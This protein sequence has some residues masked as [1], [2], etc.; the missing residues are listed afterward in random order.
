MRGGG[1]N[2][3][4]PSAPGAASVT[5]VRSPPVISLLSGVRIVD[6]TTIV[7]GPYA[8]A[9]L[10]DLGADVIKVEPPVA[11]CTGRRRR[12]A[13]PAWALPSSPSTATSARSA[14]T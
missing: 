9:I 11:T 4:T 5:R 7:L 6:L 1:G 8:T 10:G 3:A 14:S 2:V 12:H 13:T